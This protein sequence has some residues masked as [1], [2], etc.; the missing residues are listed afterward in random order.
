MDDTTD[1]YCNYKTVDCTVA[2]TKDLYKGLNL[3]K[4][5]ECPCKLIFIWPTICIR[6]KYFSHCRLLL[7]L[8]HSEG[9]AEK[10]PLQNNK[11]GLWVLHS[12][13]PFS[14][15]E[16][17]HASMQNVRCSLSC[18]L[19]D[20]FH[21]INSSVLAWRKLACTGITPS[22]RALTNRFAINIK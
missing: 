21:W 2:S 14:T 19:L 6:L 17:K 16:V 9:A 5:F 20:I 11:L 15:I 10:L 3:P 22:T 13:S 12:I 4:R 1:K 8:W 18:F 7:G